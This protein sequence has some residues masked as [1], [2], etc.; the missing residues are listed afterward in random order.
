MGY[1]SGK[2]NISSVD[3]TKRDVIKSNFERSIKLLE[4]KKENIGIISAANKLDCFSEQ[5]VS[6]SLSDS[7]ILAQKETI[8]VLTEDFL[9]LKM[10]E[11]ETKKKA[12]EYCSSLSLL[13]VLYEHK[14]LASMNT[15]ISLIIFH[16]TVSGFCPLQ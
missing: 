13:R 7:C 10:N 2:I 6:P 11:L 1:A 4:S 3:Q 16:P 14:K 9:Y 8:P 12:P 5:K 15:W